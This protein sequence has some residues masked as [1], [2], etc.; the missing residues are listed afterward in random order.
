MSTST[1]RIE[2]R[3][4]TV[5]A[6][7][8]RAILCALLA[9]VLTFSQDGGVAVS[10]KD[11]DPAFGL[12]VLGAFLVLQAV[13]LAVFSGSL[14]ISRTGR[15]LVLVRAGV[16]L[17][18]GVV[19]LAST[20]GGLALLRPLEAVVFLVLGAIEIAGGVRRT[21]RA[22]LA[23]DA[24]V[25]GGLQVLVG[26]LLGIL[27]GDVLLAVGVLGAWGAVV[28]VY[29]GISAVNLRRRAAA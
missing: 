16:S 29:L 24:V 11:R 21:E 10:S 9:I 13:V 8:A 25:V 20:G 14:S 2:R 15:L 28:A 27:N 22:E 3:S 1:S 17:V 26:L 19:A 23:G 18:G 5:L 12:L 4:G 6:V 7:A